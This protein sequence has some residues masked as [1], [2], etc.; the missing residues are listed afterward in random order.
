MLLVNYQLLLQSFF[1]DTWNKRDKFIIAFD[2]KNYIFF[3]ERPLKQ[4][5][6]AGL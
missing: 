2:V 3:W 6:S 1:N 5:L 4:N